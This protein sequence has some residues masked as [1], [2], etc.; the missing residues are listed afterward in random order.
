MGT[1]HKNALPSGYELAEYSIETVL[2]HGG[3]GITYLARDTTLGALVAVKEFLPGE[4]AQRDGTMR[5]LPNPE[6]Q[7]VRDYQAGLKNFV[8]EARALAHFKHPHIVRVL[9]FL[10]ANGTAYTVMEYEEGQSLADY[11]KQQAGPRIDEATI[12]RVFIPVLT[13]LHAVHEA[14]MLHLDIKPENIYLRKDGSPMLI[15][16]GSARRAMT[17][18]SRAQRIA[19]THGYAPIEQYPDKGAPG[20][21]TDLYALGASIYRC[22]SG[23]RPDDALSRYQAVLKYK[24]D[25][26]E[27]ATK[28]GRNRYQAQLLECV[29]WAMQIYAKDRPQSARELQDGLM[30]KRRQAAAATRPNPLGLGQVKVP[31]SPASAATREMKR[32]NLRWRIKAALGAGRMLLT[33]IALGAAIVGASIYW[34]EIKIWLGPERETVRAPAPRVEDNAPAPTTPAETAPATVS[35]ASLPGPDVVL[36]PPT[37]LE[38]TLNGHKDWVQAIAFSADSRWLATA[39]TDRT[40]KVWDVASGA[41]LGTMRGHEG[42]INA[43]AY[44]PD[45]KWLASASDD[46]SV[47]LWD[48]YSGGHRAV[49]QGSTGSLFA[50]V[51]SPDGKLLASAGRD[52]TIFIW[53]VASGKRLAA[54][55]GSK[56]DVFALA[57]TPD[58]KTLASA[59]ADKMIRI[60]N[61]QRFEELSEL[62]GHKDPILS[63]VYSPDGRL[64]A[65]G[66]AGKTLRVWDARTLLPVRPPSVGHPMLALAYSPDSRWLAAGSSDGT[67]SLFDR[68]ERAPSYTVNAHRDY[69]QSLAFSPDGQMLASGSRDRSARLWKAKPN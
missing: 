36:G 28:L 35:K 8:K 3:F 37:A 30:G 2:G 38:R 29:D 20:P 44:S 9:R 50:A 59:G 54:M 61:P 5:V 21:W 33:I 65:S 31:S 66:D 42:S 68:D 56:G 43:L 10:E 14:K 27:P 1:Y 6:R 34:N 46:G 52:R 18:T 32:A 24:T 19:L 15:D 40:I 7:A 45:G 11:L 26:L 12:L 4:I 17:E 16:F 41:L 67:V 62:A 22:I 57:F 51:F 69:V 60:W 49:L 25:P 48:G 64:L 23:K 55:E 13:G 63:L 47:R 39:S 53:D 58:G